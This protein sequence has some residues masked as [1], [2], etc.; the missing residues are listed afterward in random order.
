MSSNHPA[1]EGHKIQ[2]K[3][4]VRPDRATAGPGG[5]ESVTYLRS[6]VRRRASVSSIPQV[7]SEKDK[8]RLRKEKE[9]EKKNVDINE[10]LM[11]AQEVADKYKTG[12]NMAKPGESTGLTEQQAAQLLQDHGPNV[13]TPQKQTHPFLKY[14]GYLTSLFNLLLIVAG[15]FSSALISRTTFKT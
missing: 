5:Q 11:S 15:I 6:S 3:P 2:F 8:L 13:L 14:L 9:I 12:I 4:A 10:H 7:I 1:G